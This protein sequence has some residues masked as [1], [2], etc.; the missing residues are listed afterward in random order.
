MCQD[1][2]WV[3]KIATA[4]V[5]SVRGRST[6]VSARWVFGGVL[7]WCGMKFDDWGTVLGG[8][9]IP[10]RSG[11][12]VRYHV[13]VFVQLFCISLLPLNSMLF[14]DRDL[15]C[16]YWAGRLYIPVARSTL[17]VE[18]Q[19]RETVCASA[20]F[21]RFALTRAASVA[22]WVGTSTICRVKFY[23]QPYALT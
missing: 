20:F 7:H 5:P 23:Y 14:R 16:W 21:V 10:G 9:S 6:D 3:L 1:S 13:Q 8:N 17:Q 2:R 12:Y 11:L 18:I 22:V 4:W 19:L 15:W